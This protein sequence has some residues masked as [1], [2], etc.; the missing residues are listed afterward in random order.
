MSL[1]LKRCVCLQTILAQNII[2]EKKKSKQKTA[3]KIGEE[4]SAI[5]TYHAWSVSLLRDSTVISYAE[6][7]AL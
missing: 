1:Q 3:A 2:M 4:K 7:R 5:R 6:H